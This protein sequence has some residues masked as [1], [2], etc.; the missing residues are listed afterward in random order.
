MGA[1]AAVNLALGH[2]IIVV[3]NSDNFTMRILRAMYE[4][5]YHVDA[6][7][8]SGDDLGWCGRR[9]RFYGIC[10][11]R[12][13][14]PAA[15]LEPLHHVLS[16][17]LRD[18]ATNVTFH[19]LMVADTEPELRMEVESELSW[20][21]RRTGSPCFGLSPDEVRRAC[22]ADRRSP[23]EASLTTSERANL[24]AYKDT[25]D[26]RVACQLNQRVAYDRSIKSTP[27]TMYSIVKSPALHF[28][29]NRGRWFF[30]R[31]LLL[32]Q[33]FPILT[34]LASPLSVR[35]SPLLVTSFNFAIPG[36]NRWE[37]M[38]QA[39]NT[40]QVVS[41]GSILLYVLCFVPSTPQH[42]APQHVD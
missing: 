13:H 20:S 31:E 14:C 40:M 41:I 16:M 23:Y 28:V 8:L 29:L 11:L 7:V 5:E 27:T 6:V 2:K 1:W 26:E 37:I 10:V 21:I 12:S 22:N 17:F 19:N 15:M 30:P 36:R 25:C 9:P 4:P 33:G 32:M 3:E 39:G 35:A 42:F 24:M 34:R 38:R 18:R